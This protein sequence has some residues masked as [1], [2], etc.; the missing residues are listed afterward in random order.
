MLINVKIVLQ[1]SKTI[2]FYVKEKLKVV[3]S[4]I[5]FFKTKVT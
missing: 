3:N 2:I 5:G 1:L 4:V